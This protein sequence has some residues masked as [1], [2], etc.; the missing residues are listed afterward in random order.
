M[1]AL[2]SPTPQEQILLRERA[3]VG[4]ARATAGSRERIGAARPLAVVNERRVVAVC[5][6]L[7]TRCVLH[8]EFTPSRSVLRSVT[9]PPH[10]QRHVL[11]IPISRRL[12]AE[13]C[14]FPFTSNVMISSTR[15]RRDAAAAVQSRRDAACPISVRKS[16]SSAD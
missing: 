12:T 2:A 6:Y 15:K 14:F 3:P 11:P 16:A 8:S 1:A 9:L 13:N 10:V 4:S 7:F 5:E